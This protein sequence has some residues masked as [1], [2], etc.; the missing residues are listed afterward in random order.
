MSDPVKDIALSWLLFSL[1][2]VLEQGKVRTAILAKH[3]G[4]RFV[5]HDYPVDLTASGDYKYKNLYDY[6]TSKV[7]INDDKIH[8]FSVSNR[9]DKKTAETHFQAIIVDN[10]NK[11][12]KAIDP[13]MAPQGN[14]LYA[15]Y[16]SEHIQATLSNPHHTLKMSKPVKDWLKTYTFEWVTGTNACQ[17]NTNDVFCQ[18][19]SLYLQLKY[20]MTGHSPDVSSNES[21][22]YKVLAQF[23]HDNHEIICPYLIAQYRELIELAINNQ[24]KGM[25]E[26]IP[27]EYHDLLRQVDVC[28]FLAELSGYDIEAI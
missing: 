24:I 3:F 10:K 19:W 4:D 5:Y 13:S 25:D 9:A 28:K 17:T 12:V 11:L 6:L 27:V 7:M 21:E 20:L 1:R 15:P 26:P 18:T 8:L 14:S 22:R 2:N 16:I 23:Y